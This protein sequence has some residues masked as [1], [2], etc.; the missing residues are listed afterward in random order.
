[1]FERWIK[2]T[3]VSCA[4]QLAETSFLASVSVETVLLAGMVSG[5]VIVAFAPLAC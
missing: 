1:M 2:T 5:V 3:A 4:K